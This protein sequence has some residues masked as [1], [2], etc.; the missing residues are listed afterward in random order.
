M[1][2]TGELIAP[3]TLVQDPTYQVAQINHYATRSYFENIRRLEKGQADGTNH[4]TVANF[5]SISQENQHYFE[6]DDSISKHFPRFFEESNKWRAVADYPH[7]F[8]LH[9]NEAFL[10]SFNVVFLYLANS[11]GNYLLNE[12]N[13]LPSTQYKFFTKSEVNELISLPNI[14]G[15]QKESLHFYVDRDSIFKYFLGTVHYGDFA[16]RF[17]FNLQFS[18]RNVEVE[19]NFSIPIASNQNGLIALV[20]L[21]TSVPN[22]VCLMPAGRGDV[23]ANEKVS[24]GRFC[25]IIYIPKLRKET[26]GFE[27]TIGAEGKIR[28]VLLGSLPV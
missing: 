7:R 13:V 25:V 11:F 8:G 3:W 1:L 19:N 15:W 27:L 20:D 24:Q 9:Q 16:R 21:E 28:E 26:H 2:P 4:K 22:N 6:Y 18:L 23:I 10:S 5:V 17:G 12:Q 14:N